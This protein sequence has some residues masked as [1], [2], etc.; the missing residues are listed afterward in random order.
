ML[1]QRK[2]LNKL[3]P[4][5]LGTVDT[6]VLIYDH[7]KLE[8]LLDLALAAKENAGC[9]LLYAVKAMPLLNLLHQLAPRVDGFAISSAFEALLV[10]NH[11]PGSQLHFTSPGVRPD[12]VAVIGSLCGYVSANSR[13]QIELFGTRQDW[14]GSLGIRVNTRVSNVPDSR[15]DPCRP[16]SKLGIPVEEAT[17]LYM[18][19]GYE[20][21]GLHI[22]TNADSTDFGELLTN[23]E[24]LLEA[25]SDKVIVKWVNLGGGYL[26]EETS[27]APLS[28]AVNLVHS[29]LG[30]EVFIEPGAGMVRAAGFLVSSVLDILFVDGNRIAILDTTVNHMPE[31]LEFDYQ[32]DV[33][34][35]QDEGDFRYILAGR[36]CLAGDVFGIY[37]FADPLSVGDKIVFEDAGAYSLVKAHRFNGVN[38]PQVAVINDNG[39]YHVSKTFTYSDFESYWI[40]SA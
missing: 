9:K 30:A 26:F 28:Q 4:E 40:P 7:S 5:L 17:K 2:T 24:V 12:E 1:T 27:A 6:P 3:T 11:F 39:Q 15:Y 29:T 31:V 25:F 21:D 18:S 22:H 32:P 35:Q 20:I 16:S 19:N 8:T 33:V 38:L 23:V 37:H 14:K 34:S 36:T 13:S 10:T